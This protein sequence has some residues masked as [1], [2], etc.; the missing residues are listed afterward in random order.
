MDKLATRYHQLL[1]PDFFASFSVF[2]SGSF[3]IISFL[4]TFFFCFS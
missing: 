4:N 3:L 2:D 1:T